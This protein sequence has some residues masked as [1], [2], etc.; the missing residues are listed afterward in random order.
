MKIFTRKKIES[1]F[2]RKTEPAD[3]L[4]EKRRSSLVGSQ[5]R[6][7]RPGEMTGAVVSFYFQYRF[8]SLKVGNTKASKKSSE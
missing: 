4:P 7:T 3:V 2:R 6:H 8:I 5:F 1:A